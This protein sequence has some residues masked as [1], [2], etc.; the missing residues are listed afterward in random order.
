MAKRA[1]GKPGKPTSPAAR[2]VTRPEDSPVPLAPAETAEHN[3]ANKQTPRS[4]SVV[5]K[6]DEVFNDLQAVFGE[7]LKTA[8]LKIGLKQS[9]LAEKTGLTQ[10]YLS[11]IE[12]GQLNVTLRTMMAL[13]KVVGQDVSTMLRHPKSVFKK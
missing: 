10:Q 11:R 8:R 7:N 6:D 9:E 4:G 13:A 5:P 12:T 3:Q 2:V 1:P